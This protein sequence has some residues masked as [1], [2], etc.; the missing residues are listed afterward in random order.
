MQEHT[1][2]IFFI[3]PVK[4][5]RN[6]FTSDYYVLVR[7]LPT[8][9]GKKIESQLIYRAYELFLGV[10]IFCFAVNLI[11]MINNITLSVSWI[12]IWSIYLLKRFSTFK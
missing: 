9:F 4:E 7:S 3:D 1:E 12:D 10:T 5:Y 2:M 6:A 11:A 8:P